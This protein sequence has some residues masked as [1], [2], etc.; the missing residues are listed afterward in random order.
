MRA[1]SPIFTTII[2]S[3]SS[4]RSDGAK[5]TTETFLARR[6]SRS[7]ASSSSFFSS[8]SS[9]S[10]SSKVL[11]H[12]SGIQ[13]RRRRH[14]RQNTF[15]G[16]QS[17]S[18]TANEGIETNDETEE[19]APWAKPGYKGA[20]VSQQDNQTQILVVTAIWVGLLLSTYLSCAKVG[21]IVESI[22]PDGIFQFSK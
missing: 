18:D 21:P 2:A 13:N 6:V 11:R 12:A 16:L 3:S 5:K 22:L 19:D 14:H 10:S 7:C 8:S 1:V 9:S 17:S 20:W 4:S 15:A